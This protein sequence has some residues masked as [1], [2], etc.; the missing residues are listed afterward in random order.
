MVKMKKHLKMSHMH[1]MVKAEKKRGQEKCGTGPQ[2]NMAVLI[3]RGNECLSV[4]SSSLPRSSCL[5]LYLGNE[6]L[7][8]LSSFLSPFFPCPQNNMAAKIV[9]IINNIFNIMCFTVMHWNYVLFTTLFLPG[10]F[11]VQLLRV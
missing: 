2:K 7:V 9:F 8:S 3:L 1:F 4:S 10:M 5:Y 6:C 11:T